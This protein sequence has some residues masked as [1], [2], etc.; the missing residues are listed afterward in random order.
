MYVLQSAKNAKVTAKRQAYAHLAMNQ[1]KKLLKENVS[2][3]IV[4]P[5]KLF[6]TESV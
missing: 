3:W 2:Q 6:S 1:V 5:I 4:K